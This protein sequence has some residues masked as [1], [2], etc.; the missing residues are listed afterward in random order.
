MKTKKILYPNLVAELSRNGI[1]FTSVAK[2]LGVSRA[3]IYKKL[4]GTTNFTLKDITTIQ[5]LIKL[6][7]SNGDYTLDYL[8]YRADV[9]A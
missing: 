4:D 5:E 9:T 3:A 6:A 2:E 8:F 7:D 1:T